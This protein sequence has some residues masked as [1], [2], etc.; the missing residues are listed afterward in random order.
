MEKIYGSLEKHI[1]FKI[2]LNKKSGNEE[3]ELEGKWMKKKIQPRARL[4][5][6]INKGFSK[7]LYIC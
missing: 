1:E 2:K 6:K 3:I 4:V 7:V 5:Y